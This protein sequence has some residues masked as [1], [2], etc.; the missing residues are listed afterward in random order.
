MLSVLTGP[1][2]QPAG[3]GL[4][5]LGELQAPARTARAVLKTGSSFWCRAQG[6]SIIVG[7]MFVF[8][9]IMTLSMIAMIIMTISTR[10]RPAS[11]AESRPASRNTGRSESEH[12]LSPKA[13]GSDRTEQICIGDSFS[14]ATTCWPPKTVSQDFLEW[15]VASG[16]RGRLASKQILG[17]LLPSHGSSIRSS[18]VTRKR[19]GPLFR[20]LSST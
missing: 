9:M 3:W 2:A 10:A 1:G 4:R 14:S 6:I 18:K 19:G 13:Q 16:L 11:P 8:V 15:I 5:D 20:V 7:I 17:R 12:P